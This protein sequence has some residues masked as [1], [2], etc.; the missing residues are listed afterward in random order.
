[1]PQRKIGEGSYGCIHAPNLTCSNNK[2][3]KQKVPYKI[4]KIMKRKNAAIEKTEYDLIGKADPNKRYHLG[5]PEQCDIAV[6]NEN[7][8]AIGTCF[9]AP[10]ILDNIKDYSLLLMDYGGL[11]LRK[12]G[13]SIS[14]WPNN[15]E[16][17]TKIERFWLESHRL[18]RGVKMLLDNDLIHSDFKPQNIV[19]DEKKKRL[20]FIDFGLMQTL[21]STKIDI[22]RDEYRN[23]RCHFSHPLE[24]PFLSKFHYN[25]FIIKSESQKEEYYSR[26]LHEIEKKSS[27]CGKKIND[28][29]Y[30]IFSNTEEDLQSKRELLED[31]IDMLRSLPDSFE[32]WDTMKT[33]KTFDIYGIGFTNLYMLKAC[34]HLLNSNFYHDLRHLFLR[35][36]AGDVRKR[37][38]IKE[39]LTVY[40][41]ILFEHGLLHKFNVHFENHSYHHNKP[42]KARPARQIIDKMTFKKSVMPSASLEGDEPN[43]KGVN[44]IKRRASIRN[45]TRRLLSR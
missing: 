45:L 2:K 19:Y 31:F 15:Q 16:N 3:Y 28:F 21:K 24:A 37:I 44:T 34:K 41:N 11:S 20:N 38:E 13:I 12:Y 35:M 4:S 9:D 8:L 10:Q 43:L 6:S 23:T 39:C 14:Q 33:I 18:L 27:L 42:A 26:F 36:I 22:E 7:V 40:E 25:Y 17:R 29:F 1:M 32:K 5:D 30:Y